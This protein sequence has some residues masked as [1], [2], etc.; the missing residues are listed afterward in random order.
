MKIGYIVHD[1]ADAAVARRV[2]MLQ[3]GG[4]EVALA[5]FHRTAAAP[6]SVAGV[7]PLAL[8]RTADGKLAAR[9]LSVLAA[10]RDHA[11][12]AAF[13]GPVDALVARNLEAL[14]VASA[15]RR[16]LG[17]SRSGPLHAG[18]VPLTYEILDIHSL[19]L[20]AKGLPLRA[21]EG[22]LGAD[23][24]QVITSS[25]AFVEHYLTPLSKV[26]APVLLVENKLE[27][28][29]A[30][31]APRPAGPPWRIGLFGALRDRR[32][33]ATLAAV[34]GASGG[35]AQI[36]L[37]GKPSPAIFAD[38]PALADSLPDVTFGGPYSLPD[39]LPALYGGVHFTWCIDEYEAG[40]NSEWLLPNRLYEGCAHGAVPIARE[41]TAV[42]ARLADLG[43]G[44]VLGGEPGAALAAFLAAMTPERYAAMAAAVAATDAAAFVTSDAEC[45]ALVA[46]ITGRPVAADT[47]EPARQE[48]A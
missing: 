2:R 46:A 5:G 9:A 29:P 38:L 30:A 12:I 7:A 42:A 23:V 47:A 22:R 33:V 26:R 43:I 34:A 16:H 10:R 15:V 20:G 39:D 37:R 45:A 32:S 11:R 27:A 36:D 48:A 4:A 40:A 24:S 35:L 3:R 6:A 21:L 28:P 41:G 17:S 1:L 8:G 13:L 44:H 14:A 31:L 19:L 18:R 25:P